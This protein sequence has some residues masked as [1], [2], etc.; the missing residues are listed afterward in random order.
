MK[1]IYFFLPRRVY[2]FSAFLLVCTQAVAQRSTFYKSKSDDKTNN[3]TRDSILLARVK[4]DKRDSLGYIPNNEIFLRTNANGAVSGVN[5]NEVTK[6][7]YISIDQMLIGRTTGV[8]V[9]TPS[10]EPGKR[11]SVVIRG[12]SSLLLGNKDIFYIQPTYIIDG[13]PL[14]NEHAFAYDIQ[15]FDFNRNGTE[16]NLLGYLN[17]NDIESIEVLKDFGASAIYGPNAANG[18]IKITTKGSHPGK[19]N[20]SVNAYAGFSQKPTVD[21]INARYESDFRL[22][23]YRMYADDNQWR[24]FPKYLADSS[25]DRYYGPSN[26]DELYFRNGFTNGIQAA[27]TGG[28]PMA[29]FRF[30]IGQASEQGVYDKTGFS[31][32]N[33]SF[34]INIQ[35]LKGLVF[36][37]QVY[38]ASMN[39]KRNEFI[40]DRAGDED[41]LFNYEAPISPNRKYLQ[42]YYTD[43]ENTV[44]KNRNNTARIISNLKYVLND[45][46]QW[47]TRFAIDYNQNF[48]D[49]FVP[50]SLGEGNAFVSNFDGLNRGMILDNS[51]RYTNSFLNRHNLEI[52][53]GQYNQWDKWRYDYGKAYRGSSDYVKIYVPGDDNAHTGRFANFRLSFN[54]KDFTE[55]RLA[56]MY[57]NIG[58]NYNQKYFVSLYVRRDGTS[59]LDADHR[60]LMSPTISGAWK[61]SKENFLIDN[62]TVSNL[63]LRA[64][65]GKV[66]RL[67]MDEYYKGGPIYN[68]DAGWNGTPNMATYNGFPILNVAYG[69]GYVVPGTSWQYVNQANLGIDLA[70]F[71]DRLRASV[72]VYSKVDKNLVVKIPTMEEEGYTGILKNGMSIKNYGYE[73]SIEGDIIRKNDVQWTAGLNVYTNQNKLMALPDG[74]TELKMN[75]HRFVVGLPTDRYWLLV[76]E[77]IY[78]SDSEVPV[79]PKTGK[80]MS[81]QGVE[82]KKGDPKWKDLNGDYNIDDQDRELKGRLSPAATGGFSNTVRYKN[83]EASALFTYAFG[84]KIINEALANRFD[85][86]NREA[87]N[88]IKGIKEIAWWSKVEGDYS[89]IPMYNPWSPIAAYQPNQTLF[90]ENGSYVKLRSLTLAYTLHSQWMKERHIQNIRI[91]ATGNNLLTITPYKGGDPEAVSYF[92]YDQGYYNWAAP[93]SYTLGFNFQF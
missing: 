83:W 75:D 46:W 65:Y 8:D 25:Q 72:D 81:Y 18:V 16:T 48:R 88:D 64:S 12:A 29:N 42:Q 52:T 3:S 69:T 27:V 53:A 2:L 26:W 45:H 33:V 30:T 35:P 60:W 59:Y 73:F 54:T 85:F 74:L 84:R 93:R 51:I 68:V 11:N 80:R 40:R 13:V 66:G 37:T 91:Y 57:A 23:F 92:G 50:T 76:N 44:N 67:M 87:S 22:P 9:R 49:F 61:I 63:N 28:T 19:M 71:K 14:T 1:Y 89:K 17:M 31:R 24:A 90:L 5:M 7:P 38:G 56:S 10:A 82:L 77:G 43:L 15:R 32:Y 55:S 41:Y 6:L 62:A 39:R 4:S 86:V 70:L 34:G 20:V 58:Y 79:N 78:N 36:S 47:N 21:V